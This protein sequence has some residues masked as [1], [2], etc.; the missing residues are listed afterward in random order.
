MGKDFDPT[1]YSVVLKHRA[2]LPNPWRW[3]IYRAG[4]SSPLQW[5]SV[6]FSS[7]AMAKKAG[8]EA[9]TRLLDKLNV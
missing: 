1:D 5:S 7:M 3:E 9:L 8:K 2:P 4:R 6:Y